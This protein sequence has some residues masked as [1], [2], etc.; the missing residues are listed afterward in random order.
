MRLV[1]VDKITSESDFWISLSNKE[2]AAVLIFL[3]SLPTEKCPYC[4]RLLDDKNTS[5]F[6]LNI[7]WS[8]EDYE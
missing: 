4:G 8:S 1:D 3:N 7:D 5:R 2:K 6:A